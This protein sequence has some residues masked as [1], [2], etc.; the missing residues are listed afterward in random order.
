VELDVR[1]TSIAL[2]GVGR[3]ETVGGPSSAIEQLDAMAVGAG[4]GGA[5]LSREAPGLEAFGGGAPGGLLIG[6]LP[7]GA[8]EA[9]GLRMEDLHL[10]DLP[11]EDLPP[12]VSL[13]LPSEPEEPAPD[14]SLYIVQPPFEA[15]VPVLA[16]RVEER[17]PKEE[18]VDI[19]DVHYRASEP[20]PEPALHAFRE[21]AL[22]DEDAYHEEEP[23]APAEARRQ[24]AMAMSDHAAS[25]YARGE[26]DEA[27]NVL[28]E[29]VAPVMVE[30][31]DE[32]G[33]AVVMSRIADILY[34]RG[35]LD[36]ALRIR[37]EDEAP[38]FERLG[39]EHA[40]IV[41]LG[42]IADV[43]HA[44]GDIEEALR[45]RCEE[46]APV[47]DRLGDLPGLAVAVGKI[48]DLFY[49][50]GD[51][52]EA[53]R[54]CHQ[55]QAPIYDQIG[56]IRGRAAVMG[57]IADMLH[58]RGDL[59]EALR[60]H[61]E[62][63]EPIYRRLGDVRACVGV[64]GQIAEIHYARGELAEALRI[65][66]EE[67]LPMVREL[68]DLDSAIHILWRVSRIRLSHSN[69]DQA[70]F[71][72]ARA[73]LAEAYSLAA[74]VERLDAVCATASDYGRVCAAMGDMEKA[75][76]LLIEARDGYVRLGWMRDARQI[77]EQLK[78]LGTT[79]A[80]PGPRRAA[81]PNG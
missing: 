56:D 2:A 49:A 75:R 78:A 25:L 15:V 21:E 6:D 19:I 57:R 34:E 67:R 20:E 69:G 35:D 55:E 23:V 5:G 36:E 31:G 40:R 26:L 9:E 14:A 24:R 46:E 61:R 80:G 32:R 22:R 10:E 48:A 66:E 42:K 64:L 50:R 81:G 79:G 62:E 18:A 30:L 74:G 44:R 58:Q 70:T 59:D 16:T 45:I 53:L 65:H 72:R 60:I 17:E 27:L 73:S 12:H 4:D 76:A 29:D 38:V 71:E 39:D 51:H 68:G 13:R 3:T 7:G 41:T 33:R 28:R 37:C 63:E 1:E 11:P 52:D 43:L 77:E 54:I 8:G 47:L